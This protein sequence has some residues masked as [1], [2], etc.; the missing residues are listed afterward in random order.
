VFEG[1]N[2]DSRTIVF[3]SQDNAHNMG[4]VA[5]GTEDL[6]LAIAQAPSGITAEILSELQISAQQ[7]QERLIIRL[8]DGLSVETDRHFRWTTP[9]KRLLEYSLRQRLLRDDADIA[10]EHMLLA[11][12]LVEGSGSREILAELGTD[13]EQIQVCVDKRP[14]R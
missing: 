10:P 12:A 11:S 5:V 14:R 8:G 1:F 13:F 3:A 2:A 6:L 9:A 7:I 4:R